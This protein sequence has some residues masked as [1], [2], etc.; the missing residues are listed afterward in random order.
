MNAPHR[1]HDAT[2]I[3][4]WRQRIE[5]DMRRDEKLRHLSRSRPTPPRKPLLARAY[6]V[7]FWFLVGVA[8]YKVAER[9]M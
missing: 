4:I 1:F 7:A 5:E 6:V 9:W 2:E 8:I 3:A